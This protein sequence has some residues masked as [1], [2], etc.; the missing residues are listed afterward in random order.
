MKV[1][2]TSTEEEL[3]QL[4]ENEKLLKEAEDKFKSIE[5]ESNGIIPLRGIVLTAPQETSELGRF[6]KI[7]KEEFRNIRK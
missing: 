6:W 2:F 3:K 1:R 7:F 5:A 4:K